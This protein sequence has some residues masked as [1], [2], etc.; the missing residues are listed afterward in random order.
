[1][2]IIQKIKEKGLLHCV[3]SAFRIVS[4]EITD[5]INNLL[6]FLAKSCF[7]IKENRIVLESEGDYSDNGQALYAYMRDHGYLERYEVIWLASE[8]GILKKRYGL[9]ACKRQT[10]SIHWSTNYY[11]A[12]CKYY[13]Y[14]HN[15]RFERIHKRKEQYLLYITHGF[16]YKAAKGYDHSKVK[17]SFD[18][19]VVT[20]DIPAKGNTRFW[21][22]EIGRA[23]KLGYPRIDY[24]FS[25]LSSVKEAV[26]QAY[27]FSDFSSVILWM[28]TF[29]K[30]NARELSEEYLTNE[31]GLPLFHTRQDLEEFQTFLNEHRILFILKLHHLQADL[32]IFQSKFSNL[33]IVKDDSLFEKDIQ[34]YQFIALTDAL[35]TDYSS[36]SVDYMLLDRP[37]IYTLDDYEE[38]R[39]SR[40]IWPENAIDF[41]A[42]YH[43]YTVEDLKKAIL[44][45]DSGLDIYKDRRNRSIGSFHTYAD[46]NS[47][48]RIL[49]YLE[50]SDWQE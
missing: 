24:F 25:D 26:E 6:F 36:I 37:I 29:R 3:D 21:N 2:N 19:M 45:I 7:P 17:T 49:D 31:T 15:N 33:L 40:G 44:E 22:V 42:G 1:M 46:G 23:V 48:K 38:Y 28:P 14:D 11:L 43:V 8:P 39:A 18:K 50:R 4:F 47:S 27:H 35:V 5:S 34:L 32:P 16:S 10:T 41:M 9:K 30:S 20:G 13:I 12:T